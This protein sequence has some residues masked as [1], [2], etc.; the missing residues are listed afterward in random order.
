MFRGADTGYARISVAKPVEKH[1]I[2]PGMGIK[3]LRDGHDS[4][5]FVCSHSVDG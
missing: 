1:N 5:N 2:A 4:A 3:L